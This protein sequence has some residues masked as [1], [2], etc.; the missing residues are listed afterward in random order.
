MAVA[1]SCSWCHTMNDI[2]AGPTLCRECGH[3]ADLC[4]ME[5]DCPVCCGRSG[6]PFD[7]PAS[8]GG[9]ALEAARKRLSEAK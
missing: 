5:C 8:V 6:K 3:R 4:R 7:L 2:T 9:Q 1:Q